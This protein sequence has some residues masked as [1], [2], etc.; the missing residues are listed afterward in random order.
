MLGFGLWGLDFRVLWDSG[1]V[2]Y[3]V[4]GIAAVG[5][6]AVGQ[7]ESQQEEKNYNLGALMNRSGLAGIFR[8]TYVHI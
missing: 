5:G 7:T 2:G 1:F 6:E 3:K 8:Q 4:S